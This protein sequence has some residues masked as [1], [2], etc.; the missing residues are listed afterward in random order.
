MLFA[1]TLNGSGL[2]IGRTV[3]AILENFQ[4]RDESVRV[5][6]GLVGYMGGVERMEVK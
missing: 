5:P 6:E 1:Y 2:A 4:E 3:V